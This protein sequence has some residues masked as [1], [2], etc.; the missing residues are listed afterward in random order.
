MLAF[1]FNITRWNNII[2]NCGLC[3]LYLTYGGDYE[4][5]NCTFANFWEFGQRGTPAVFLNTLYGTVGF[6][7]LEREYPIFGNIG[8]SYAFSKNNNAAPRRWVLWVKGGL[9]F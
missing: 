5:T 7:L 1:N 2:A 3:N 9:S 4:F 6:H 8:A